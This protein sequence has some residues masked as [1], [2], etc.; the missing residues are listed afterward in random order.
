MIDTVLLRDSL[1]DDRTKNLPRNVF[2]PVN[3]LFGLKAKMLLFITFGSWGAEN[4]VQHKLVMQLYTNRPI[5][6]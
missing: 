2:I 3:T 6:L 4:S 5:D 1:L